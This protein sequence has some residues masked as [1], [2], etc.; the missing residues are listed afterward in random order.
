M[1]PR[2]SGQDVVTTRFPS[3]AG[4]LLAEELEATGITQ[5]QL[6][7]RLG[8]PEQAISEII[9]GKKRVTSETALE[10]EKVLGISAETWT[11]LESHAA[12]MAARESEKSML[13]DFSSWATKFPLRELRRRGLLSEETRDERLVM[14]LLSF[15]RMGSVKAW[16]EHYTAKG[17]A[18]F[19]I[20]PGASVS[21]NSLAVW[22]AQG[23]QLASSIEC[24]AYDEQKFLQA[25]VSA[26]AMVGSQP[27]QFLT[28]LQDLLAGAGVA[29]VVVPEY[30][31]SGANG[32]ARWLS[33]KKAL[34]QLSLR[35][36]WSDIFWFT[37]FH[38]AKHIV[39]YS[40]RDVIVD[41]G[42]ARPADAREAA[43]DQFAGDYL[44]N[45]D[46]W[47]QFIKRK[48]ITEPRIKRFADAVSISPGVIVGRLQH[49]K[50]LPRNRL[51][52][53]RQRF[54]WVNRNANAILFEA[55][56]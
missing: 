54:Q 48:P 16:D 26:R 11:T 17:T 13:S 5:R 41:F 22:L 36:K 52:K 31:N 40:P 8:R 32:A 24:L 50:L 19:R 14:E 56:M 39:D 37:F 28:T 6:A 1:S 21:P 12:L 27:E 2:P 51:N 25:L 29:F 3:G 55:V 4:R 33:P 30:P 18:G 9:R 10:L 44:I 23:E 7:Q 34:I 35:F 45:P 43:A 46:L 42:D 53:L 20:T 15:F 38:E 47:T 49:E